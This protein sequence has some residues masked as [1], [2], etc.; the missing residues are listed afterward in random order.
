MAKLSSVPAGDATA[1]RATRQTR[2]RAGSAEP[3]SAPRRATKGQS[4]KKRGKMAETT[5]IGSGRLTKPEIY[6]LQR[7]TH[8]AGL[9]TVDE[10]TAHDE[11]PER[12]DAARGPE[13]SNGQAQD[14]DLRRISGASG[15]SG[16]TAKTSFTQEEAESLDPEIM[17]DI[18]P[19]L[20]AASDKLAQFLVP[21]GINTKAETW[22]EIRTPGSKHHKQ[23]NNRVAT[24]NVHKPSFGSQEY[25]Q[26]R[27]IL[28]ALMGD[29]SA[30]ETPAPWRPDNIIF[31]INLNQMLNSLLIVCDPN[32]WT[33]SALDALERLHTAYPGAIAGTQ[34][35]MEAFEFYI[36]LA[37]QLT[38]AR[39]Q[40]CIESGSQSSLSSEIDSA[41][42][43]DSNQF[44]YAEALGLEAIVDQQ[45]RSLAYS[46]VD[47][48][49][50]KLKRP[51]EVEGHNATAAYGQL[52]D[53]YRWDLLKD[54]A[55]RYYIHR[56]EYLARV[57]RDVGGI[58]RILK[59]LSIEA[60]R[61]TNSKIYEQGKERFAKPSSTPRTSLGGAGGMSLLK[62]RLSK[63]S[64]QSAA[65]VAQMVASAEDAD[66]P[67]FSGDGQLSQDEAHNLAG[68]DLQE[69]ETHGIA[70]FQ[71]MQR[72][73]AQQIRQNTQRQRP[74]WTDPQS[75]AVRISAIDEDVQQGEQASS[76]RVKRSQA[77]MNDDFDPTQDEGFQTDT[78][79][80]A[81]ADRRRRE[82]TA[83]QATVD[84]TTGLEV[85]DEMPSPSKRQRLNPGSSIPP[86]T[87]QY[88]E[89]DGD[90]NPGE[91]FRRA[92]DVAKFN[93]VAASQ[94]KISRV[95]QPWTITEESALIALVSEHGTEGVSY[96]ALK[97]IDR[98]SGDAKLDRRSAEDLRFKARNMK[99]TLLK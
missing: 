60:E 85:Q 76:M 32:D 22:K 14:D 82:I 2:S 11:A 95:R 6:L 73:Q 25:I 97:A 89:D 16:T 20:A 37:A 34:F 1:A 40:A 77:E 48:V 8:L 49:V 66:A 5:E 79:D 36:H 86:L 43:D 50:A 94:A 96:S 71:E 38:I 53:E 47:D 18:L 87:Q 88:A 72:Q 93:R 21:A 44:R 81:E 31:K 56:S 63:V 15:I 91:I 68:D 84:P 69:D 83:A 55:V 23:Y 7:L 92:K 9:S 13:G 51:F 62:K 41:F 33:K 19:D 67:D 57:I 99:L 10:D 28:R 35:S 26:P 75:G 27:I 64:Q 70:A 98:D 17:I 59:G 74:R 80:I 61:R 42:Y 58:A 24:I 52:K 78:R 29:A 46:M 12:D 65:P 90:L 3:E 30:M 4:A 45:E 54:Q 39:L